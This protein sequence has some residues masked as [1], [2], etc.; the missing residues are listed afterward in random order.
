MENKYLEILAELKNSIKGSKEEKELV[1][2][3]LNDEF[4]GDLKKK[5][6][7]FVSNHPFYNE[8][9]SLNNPKGKIDKNNCEL[10]LAKGYGIIKINN[11]KIIYQKSK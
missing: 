2:Q 6:L 9:L 3:I 1:K 5:G 8:L 4:W 11:G 10:T 7:A